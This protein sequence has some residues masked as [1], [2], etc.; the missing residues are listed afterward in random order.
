MLVSLS[1]RKSVFISQYCLVFHKT[2]DKRKSAQCILGLCCLP[3]TMLF[4]FHCL[5]CS[6]GVVAL[7]LPKVIAQTFSRWQIYILVESVKKI[8]EIFCL[9]YQKLMIC[10]NIV[11]RW[12]SCRCFHSNCGCFWWCF[13]Q[14]NVVHVLSTRSCSSFAHSWCQ[15]DEWY[16]IW[17]ALQ[18]FNMH[19]YAQSYPA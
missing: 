6:L 12:C 11:R 15:V 2:E 10:L 16:M 7:P 17:Y 5:S 4:I 8:G 3:V 1:N 14:R 13:G 9:H 18:T 19:S